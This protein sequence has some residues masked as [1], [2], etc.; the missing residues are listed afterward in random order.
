M[1][2]ASRTSGVTVLEFLITVAIG[3]ILLTI[4]VPS[5]QYVTVNNR[6]AGEVNGLL[7]DM[8]YARY[9]AIKEGVLVTVCPSSDGVSCALTDSWSGGWIVKSSS[10]NNVLR[11]QPA[12]TSSDTFTTAATVQSIAFNREGFANG[13]SAVGI[14]TLSLHD[15]TN[16][17]AYTRCLV[18]GISGLLTTQTYGPNAATGVT[19]T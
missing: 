2:S 3:T 12:F 6:M 5:Y 17:T 8:L 14:V 1:E 4:A 13:L 7:G 16:N 19:C 11:Y 15:P 9:E 18:V 10:N